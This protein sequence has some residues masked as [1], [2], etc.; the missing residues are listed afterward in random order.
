LLPKH[1]SGKRRSA[2]SA[3]LDSLSSAGR[4]NDRRFRVLDVDP[5]EEEDESSFAGLLR[6]ESA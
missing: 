2:P 5:F 4:R 1:E 6:V 3:I